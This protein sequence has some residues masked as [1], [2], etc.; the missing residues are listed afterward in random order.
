MHYKPPERCRA[1]LAWD[2]TCR[3]E[4]A[5]TT[6]NRS[7]DRGEPEYA[8]DRSTAPNLSET[9]PAAAAPAR[10]W[11]HRFS[12]VFQAIGS[13]FWEILAQPIPRF[14]RFYREIG[15]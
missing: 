12:P 6:A 10:A 14:I 13:A 3:P 9:T 5:R 4:S 15:R 11:S 7:Q 1:P 2:G 8:S